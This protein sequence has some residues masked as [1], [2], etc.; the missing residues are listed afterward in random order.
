MKE[1]VGFIKNRA[2][3]TIAAATNIAVKWVWPGK[4]IP[5]MQT[6]LTGIEGDSTASPPLPGQ[7]GT[8]VAAERAMMT[9]RGAWDAGLHQLHGWTMNGIALGKTHFGDQPIKRGLLANLTARG[10]SRADILAEALAWEAAWSEADAT[11]TPLAGIT[12]TA[13]ETLRLQCL[14]TLQDDYNKAY[15]T[16][17]DQVG[18]LAQIAADLEKVLVAWYS[19]A[20]RVFP[21]GTPEGDMIRGTVPTTYTPTSK[22]TPPPPAPVPTSS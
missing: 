15:S 1:T 19:D 17:R 12:L 18:A 9:A 8:A 14:T 5:E 3:K 16:W 2:G 20:T 13:F 7:E 6:M 11:Y 10:A 4:T 22:L 21:A